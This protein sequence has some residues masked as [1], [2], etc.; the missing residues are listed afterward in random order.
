VKLADI[1][2]TCKRYNR[3]CVMV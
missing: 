1:V 3:S 2:R